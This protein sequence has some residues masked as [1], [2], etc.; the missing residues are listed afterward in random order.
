MFLDISQVF[1][2]VWHEGFDLQTETKWDI[3]KLLII[4]KDFFDPAEA[5]AKR[6]TLTLGKIGITAGCLKVQF[7]GLCSF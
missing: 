7:E 3:M 5:G 4:L 2:E 6:V 1:D